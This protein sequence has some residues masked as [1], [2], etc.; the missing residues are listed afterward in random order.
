MLESVQL[1]ASCDG[2]LR[3]VELEHQLRLKELDLKQQEIE[4]KQREIDAQFRLKEYDLETEKIKR[5]NSTITSCQFRCE[6]KH[7]I[8]P[9]FQ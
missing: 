1:V 7:K 4:L 9:A 5:L 8:G 6:Q 3:K 2:E